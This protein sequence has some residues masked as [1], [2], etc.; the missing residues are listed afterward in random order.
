M[1][2]LMPEVK[3]TRV[4]IV[5]DHPLFSKGLA[6]LIVGTG[7][8]GYSVAGE[9]ASLSEAMKI[10]QQEKPALAIVDISLGEENG[11][12]LIPRLK[13]LDQDMAILVLSMH[14]ER[15]WSERVLRLGARGYIMKTEPP[16]KVLDAIK[17]VMAGKVYLSDSERERILEAMTGESQRGVKD[18]AAS[19][20][21][22]SNRELQVFSCMGKGMGTIEIAGKFK[23]STKTIDTH[24]E[25]IKLKLHCDSSHE[26]RRLAIEWVNHPDLPHHRENP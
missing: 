13:S 3:T 7:K 20:R 25:H 19:I 12:D 14:D 10:A 1:K 22:L 18:V 15:Y 26:L 16:Q 5:E 6:S 2:L 11:M 23:L 4:M 9:A 24:K 17:T 21:K 8:S